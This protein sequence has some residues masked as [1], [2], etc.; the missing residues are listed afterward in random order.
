MLFRGLM[1]KE[2]RHTEFL[3]LATTQDSL[4]FNLLLIDHLILLV[5]LCHLVHL[6]PLIRI[7]ILLIAVQPTRLK[8]V[9]M[10]IWA[11]VQ[12]DTKTELCKVVSKLN[13]PL[14]VYIYKAGTS[15]MTS[16][17]WVL[18]GLGHRGGSNDTISNI[19]MHKKLHIHMTSPKSWHFW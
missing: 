7:L 18:L 9:K 8:S 3:C 11:R 1:S 4:V 16:L 13:L 19:E 12:R 5:H 2:I 17:D 14:K 15:L 6:Q 10:K